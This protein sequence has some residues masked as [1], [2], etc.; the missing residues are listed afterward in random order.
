DR[1]VAAP[2][3]GRRS[4]REGGLRERRE[5]PPTARRCGPGARSRVSRRRRRAHGRRRPHARRRDGQAPAALGLLD[6]QHARRGACDGRPMLYMSVTHS[7]APETADPDLRPICDLGPL[8]DTIEPRRYLD[9]QGLADEDMAW[10]KRF[11]MKGAFLAELSDEYVHVG[12]DAV[13]SAP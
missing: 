12:L 3:R 6:R 9:V 2:R 5:P 13:A 8:V 4:R 7:G 10:G 11:Y 1:S